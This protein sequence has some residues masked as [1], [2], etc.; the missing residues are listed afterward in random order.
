MFTTLCLYHIVLWL[1]LCIFF[2]C[3]RVRDINGLFVI[4][5]HA[6]WWYTLGLQ[7]TR[8]V[9]L[10][11]SGPREKIGCVCVFFNA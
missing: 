3:A 7:S 4:K 1:I 10:I 5:W 2:L 9:E 6:R 8:I 11:C